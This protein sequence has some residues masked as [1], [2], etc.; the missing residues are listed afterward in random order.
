MR[1]AFA[2]ELTF[3]AQEYTRTVLLSGDIGNRLFDDFKT[4][5]P[6]RF[7]NCGVAEANMVSMA[8]GMA[9]NGLIPILYTIASFMVYRPF[10]Q[11]RVDIA[12]PCLP[13]LIVGVGAGLS[14]AS[15]GPTHHTLEDI[16]LMRA[17]PKM[18]VVCPGDAWEVRAALRGFLKNPQP[19]YLRLGKKGE[20][21]I[22]QEVP[23][24]FEIGKALQVRK[25]SSAA[26]L[27]TGNMV[28]MALKIAECLASEGIDLAVYSFHTIKPLDHEVL[29]CCFKQYQWTFTLEEHSCIGGFG[30]AVAEWLVD[31]PYLS[32]KLKRLCFP[33]RFIAE[34]GNQGYA[35]A[36]SG[37]TLASLSLVIQE[38]LSNTFVHT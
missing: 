9:M 21:T 37:F 16:A 14:Y 33:D 32:G 28:P 3:L 34:T 38:T 11:I 6:E 17:L 4:A 12:Y 30:S 15:N 35:R 1:N 5:N 36:L 23:E 10:E 2:Q 22:H 20:A 19:T 7:F 25:G 13:V 31:R 29:Q 8:S 18:Q 27:A 26:L 24:T